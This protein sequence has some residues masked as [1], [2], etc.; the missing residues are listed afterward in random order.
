MQHKLD[1]SAA[2]KMNAAISVKGVILGIPLEAS[3]VHSGDK[4]TLSGSF[5]LTTSALVELLNS[6]QPGMGDS[7]EKSTLYSFAKALQGKGVLVWQSGGLF[8]AAGQTDNVSVGMIRQD[9]GTILLITTAN[10]NSSDN[11]SFSDFLKKLQKTLGAVELR[12]AFKSGSGITFSEGDELLQKLEKLAFD[13]PERSFVLPNRKELNDAS[14]L[15]FAG[16]DLGKSDMGF[17]N[18]LKKVLPDGTSLSLTAAF[19][20]KFFVLLNAKH[21]SGVLEDGKLDIRNLDCSLYLSDSPTLSLR[22]DLALKINGSEY[23]F[24]IN[25]SAKGSEFS[26]SAEYN[27]TQ[28]PISVGSYFK[29]Y[30]LGISVGYGVSG[31]V[32]GG[33]GMVRLGNLDLFALAFMRSLAGATSLTAL[34]LSFNK[35]NLPTLLS[36][37]GINLPGAEQFDFLSIEPLPLIAKTM[38]TSVFKDLSEEGLKKI[39]DAFSKA[40]GG[41]CGGRTPVPVTASTIIVRQSGKGWIITDKSNVRHYSISEKG[42]VALSP[43]LYFCT[44]DNISAGSYTL[45]KGMFVCAS[46]VIL[47]V[48]LNLFLEVT[49][50]IGTEALV[51]ITPID[52]GWLKL[53]RTKQHKRKIA[54]R[55]P[56]SNENSLVE[57]YIYDGDGPTLYLCMKRNDFVFYLDASLELLGIIELDAYLM[58]ESG[59]FHLDAGLDF[60]GLS[61]RITLI[62]DYSSANNGSFQFTV[63]LDLSFFQNIAKD[64]VQTVKK[65]VSE[66]QSKLSS[67]QAQLDY[68]QRQVMGLQSQIDRVN[69]QISDYK[70]Q[71]NNL[72]WWQFYKAPYLLLVIGGLEMEKGGIYA[73]MGAA[74]AALE[75]AK[76]VLELLKDAAG[77]VGW[78][79]QKLAEA[80]SSIFYL[81]SISLTLGA[82]TAGKLYADM[83]V[84][85]TLFGKDYEAGGG[86]SLKGDVKNGI[87]S[88]A[89]SEVSNKTDEELNKMKKAKAIMMRAQDTLGDFLKSSDFPYDDCDGYK[90]CIN[91]GLDFADKAAVSEG[92]MEAAYSIDYGVEDPLGEYHSGQMYKKLS[93][94]KAQWQGTFSAVQEIDCGELLSEARK[95]LDEE[96]N[97]ELDELD[98]KWES[99]KSLQG[100]IDDQSERI[101]ELDTRYLSD[102]QTAKAMFSKALAL[103]NSDESGDKPTNRY[104]TH[105]FRIFSS[106][107]NN[108]SGIG[109]EGFVTEDTENYYIN[110]ANEPILDDLFAQLC[111]DSP[112]QEMRVLENDAKNDAERKRSAVNYK[113]RI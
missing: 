74:Y 54:A 66:A 15:V 24:I 44:D 75:L 80:I 42:S 58:I 62:A 8:A 82:E 78:L 33:W 21:D 59:K 93:D 39:A 64:V 34:G 20:D 55:I 69:R 111:A 28:N 48:R 56:V 4:S 30:Q 97:S 12:F 72:H 104:C 17:L 25:S 47:G 96:N 57:Q 73:A 88:K 6:I 61:A 3:I 109:D 52:L 110:P 37:F 70:R 2:E 51:N 86:V 10:E 60:F 50:K 43:Q 1:D 32:F 45:Y 11:D 41:D 9:G 100:F 108:V 85:F 79:I 71:L 19:G 112:N 23:F 113:I 102:K 65:F 83:R 14:V 107:V 63:M 106:G 67:A 29:M 38:D 76:K 18:T 31:L 46:L 98:K 16:A 90:K 101:S 94:V 7:F 68:A 95:L 27:G 22:G 81:K 13:K 92:M 53:K 87:N 103:E 89:H 5:T 49:D 84:C 91:D 77:A 99:L 40:C 36:V 26:I 35:M 105:L